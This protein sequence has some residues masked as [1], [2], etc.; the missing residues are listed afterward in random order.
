ML[1]FATLFAC[2][3]IQDIG[4][5]SKESSPTAESVIE[6]FIAAKGGE[7]SLRK[8][9][10]VSIKGSVFSNDE[11]VGAFE[12][13][14]AANRHLSINRFPDGSSL[15]H[16][17]DGKLAWEIDV[18][19]KPT[20]LEGQRARDYIR[21]YETLHESL[22][23]S[24]QF[25]AILYAGK[26]TVQDT[27]SHHLIFV[28]PDNRQINRYFSIESGLLIREE[29]V[30]G[31]GEDTQILVS[32][33]GDYV[34]DESGTTVSRRR[35]NHFGAAYSIEYRIESVESNTLKDDSLFKVPDTVTELEENPDLQ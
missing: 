9:K 22:E 1:F 28:A 13:Y 27:A 11:K 21:H 35:L 8:I 17:T 30:E 19:G 15:R 6:K 7:S 32:E 25:N 29:Q 5:D 4:Q 18:K 12:I 2:F 31:A 26:K 33:I 23:W 16:G 34:R 24:K 20:L 10:N 3:A 14:Q